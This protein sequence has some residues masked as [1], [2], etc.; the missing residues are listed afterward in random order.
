MKSLQRW[1]EKRREARSVTRHRSRKSRPVLESLESRVVLY[2]ASGNAWMNPEIITISF[3]PDG[4]NLG[5]APSN[6]V[7]TFNNNPA[8]VG[9]WQNIILKAAQTWAQQTNINFVVVPDDGAPSGA[10]VDQEGDPNHGDIR[11]GG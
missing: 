2:S 4:T 8:L 9:K 6:M 7:S 5:S 10:G 3:M 1:F 11:I